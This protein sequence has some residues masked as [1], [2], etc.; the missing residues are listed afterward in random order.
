MDNS[1]DIDALLDSIPALNEPTAAGSSPEVSTSPESVPSVPEA[2][3][4][5]LVADP[6]ASSTEVVP[7]GEP[8]IAETPP[9]APVPDVSAELAAMKAQLAE[10]GPKA[11][12]VDLA[13]QRAAEDAAQAQRDAQVQQWQERLDYV[14]ENFSSTEAAAESRRIVGEIEQARNSEYQQQIQEQARTA[15]AAAAIGTGL[16]Q[17]I[18]NHPLIPEEVKKELIG[19]A[20]FLSQLPNPQAQQQTLVRDR[21]IAESAV[22]R[23]E[24]KWKSQLESATAAKVQERI[25]SGVDQVGVGVGSPGT[26]TDDGSLDFVIDRIYGT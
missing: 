9:A 24:A 7:S 22:A 26:A 11:Q 18:Q 20:Q 21:Q 2:V 23:A 3:A 1:P 13:M 25:A 19:N 16:Y 14:R 17:S 4:P 10:L 12:L 6:N 15:N 8:A 5:A